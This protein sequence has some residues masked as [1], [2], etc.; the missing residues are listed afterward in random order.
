MFRWST[1][2]LPI[3]PEQ[4]SWVNSR[5]QW[6]L[7]QFGAV[8]VRK[9]R[10]V[11]PTPEFFPDPF[12]GAEAE[13]TPM[14]HRVCG[15]MGVD[16]GRIELYLYSD[17][18][19]DLGPGFHIGGD[20]ATAAGLYHHG[21]TARIGIARSQIADPMSLAATLAHELGHVLLLGDQRISHD[22]EDHEPLTDLLT[23]FLGLGIFGANSAVRESN[24]RLGGGW[25]RWTVGRLGY[26]SQPTWGYGLARFAHY[27][28]E[29]KPPWARH[30][31][32]DIRAALKV[33][34][35]CLAEREGVADA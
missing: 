10:V 27:R 2:K 11:L 3:S 35:R 15:Y 9:A 12:D 20:R 6:L 34:L 19:P 33:S 23:I 28:G 24:E 22:A 30:L 16:P 14:L 5:A 25:H 17:D 7:Q 1:P 18:A 31:R 4:Q 29:A 26:L 13:V 32:P 21:Q 8:R